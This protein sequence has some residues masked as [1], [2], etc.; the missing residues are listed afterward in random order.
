MPRAPRARG[1]GPAARRRLDRH[2]APAPAGEG[3]RRDAADGSVRQAG[4]AQASAASSSVSSSA[5]STSCASSTSPPRA[6]ACLP[7]PGFGFSLYYS[8]WSAVHFVPVFGGDPCF[9][10]NNAPRSLFMVARDRRGFRTFRHPGPKGPCPPRPGD[11]SSHAHS[12][13]LV[14]GT[15]Q[16]CPRSPVIVY[17]TA[18]RNVELDTRFTDRPFRFPLTRRKE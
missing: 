15:S 12:L 10:N 11:Q 4:A 16:L 18:L 17:R 1:R 9:P 14:K 13:V 6:C 3:S 7:Q 8:L 5:S 2:L